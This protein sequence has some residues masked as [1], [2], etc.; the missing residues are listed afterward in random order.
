MDNNKSPLLFAFTLL[1][2]TFSYSQEEMW[3][4]SSSG[5]EPLQIQWFK[6]AKFG[7]FIHWGLYSQL[8]GTYNGKRYYGSGEWI[9][10]QAKIPAMEYARIAASFNPVNFD[11]NKWASLAKEAGVRYLVI[12]AKHHE[13][14]AMYHSK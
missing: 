1:I 8:G 3:D 9:M 6:D 13:G 4:K 2:C 11:A 14:F 7:L 10:S 12:T 5:N